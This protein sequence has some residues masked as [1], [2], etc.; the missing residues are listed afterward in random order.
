MG[1]DMLSRILYGTR[2]TL[3]TG[4]LSIFFGGAIGSL[5]G[6]LAAF[7]KRLDAFIM[8]LMDVLFSFPA[9][10][11]GLAI[12]GIYGPGVGGIVLALT[13][14][15]IPP[16]CR[17][18]RS[19]AAT[20]VNQDYVVSGRVIGLSDTVLIWRYVVRNCVSSIFVYVTLRFGQVILLG[21]ALSFLGL[22][23]PPPTAE[24]GTMVSQGRSFL[25]MAPHVSIFPSAVIFVIVLCLNLLGDI[26]RDIL[27]PRLQ[28]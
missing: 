2:L 17:M 13:I 3:L 4:F 12:V 19:S 8:R 10:L 26:L 20:V 1:R 21:S 5:C 11:L 9:I 15:S 28:T 22:G 16:V 7:F 27:D 6:I 18:A 14:S 23:A 25:F 24:L